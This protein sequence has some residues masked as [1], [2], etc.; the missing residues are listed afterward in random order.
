MQSRVRARWSSVTHDVR[1]CNF[2]GTF[3][4]RD[5]VNAAILSFTILLLAISE[6]AS[7]DARTC[8]DIRL[9]RFVD[10]CLYSVMVCLCSRVVCVEWLIR[11]S[12]FRTNN[13]VYASKKIDIEV[14]NLTSALWRSREGRRERRE[15]REIDASAQWPPMRGTTRA[16]W[17]PSKRR[18]GEYP[19]SHGW[20]T[21]YRCNILV[22]A[23][24]LAAIVCYLLYPDGSNIPTQRKNIAQR[25]F[26]SHNDDPESWG[27]RATIRI[28]LGLLYRSYPRDETSEQKDLTQWQRLH[29]YMRHL[30]ARDNLKQYKL[31]YLTR[32]GEGFRKVREK[33]VGRAERDVSL[34]DPYRHSHAADTALALKNRAGWTD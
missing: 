19:N 15:R 34:D 21:S 22:V 9:F 33:E 14:P 29:R 26:F 8:V 20:V 2:G 5:K 7:I 18:R 4:I 10:G 17:H 12:I 13:G 25:G 1:F 24:A 16:R 28:D 11:R 23:V 31:L 3:S 6:E 32:H 27:F 30:N